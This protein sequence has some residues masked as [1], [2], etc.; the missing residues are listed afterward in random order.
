MFIS[1]LNTSSFSDE[2]VNPSSKLNEFARRE[3]QDLI[4]L[5]P[6][7]HCEFVSMKHLL[8]NYYR[9]N[10]VNFRSQCADGT[11]VLFPDTKE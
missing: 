10:S 7:F 11:V 9:E 2:S 3:S 5:N 4:H 6:C 8:N 1:D